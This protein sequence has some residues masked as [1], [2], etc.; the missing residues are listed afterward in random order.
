MAARLGPVQQAIAGGLDS[1]LGEGG[2]KGVAQA[3]ED[4]G[5]GGGGRLTLDDPNT[6]RGADPDEVEELVKGWQDNQTKSGGGTKYFW[7]G[8]AEQYGD[9]VRIMP[10][11]PAVS[12]PFHQGPYVVVTRSGNKWR[13][14]LKGNPTLQ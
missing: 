8:K 12:D 14:P 1:L 10:G 9:Q 11:D 3:G 4:A 5:N 2:G 6:L 13:I 7:P